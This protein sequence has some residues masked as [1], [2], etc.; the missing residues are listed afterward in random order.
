KPQFLIEPTGTTS[1]AWSTSGTGLGINAASGFTGNFQDW[2]LNGVSKAS[3]SYL[4]TLTTTK[5]INTG[6]GNINLGSDYS[7]I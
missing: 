5:S 6:G 2:Q 7:Q 3:I 4:G 1:T